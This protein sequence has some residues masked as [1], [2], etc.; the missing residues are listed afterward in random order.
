MNDWFGWFIV[1]NATFNNISVIWWQ[2][3]LLVEETG[4]PGENHRP[5]TNHWQI[6]DMNEMHLSMPF[7]YVNTFLSLYNK[8]I[9]YNYNYMYSSTINNFRYSYVKGAFFS[10]WRKVWT[11]AVNR[12]NTKEKRGKGKMITWHMKKT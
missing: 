2:S 8:M 5:V 11:E 12:Y 6:G 7:L 10:G 3:V 1:F 4:V 9:T